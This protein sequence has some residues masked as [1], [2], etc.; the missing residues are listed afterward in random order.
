MASQ[1]RKK[2]DP[3]EEARPVSARRLAALAL[4]PLSVA[5]LEDYVQLLSEIMRAQAMIDHKRSI[6][7][8]ADALF[9]K[10]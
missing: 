8:G 7:R 4:E 6:L 9:R 2:C 5:D 1:G 10:S 3:E